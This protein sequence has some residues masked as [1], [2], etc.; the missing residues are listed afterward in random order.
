MVKAPRITDLPVSTIGILSP[1][2]SSATM[3]LGLLYMPAMQYGLN[4]SVCYLG[5]HGGC[6]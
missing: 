3:L 4:C 5:G 1:S 2:C 6:E